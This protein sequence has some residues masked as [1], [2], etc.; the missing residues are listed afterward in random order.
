MSEDQKPE[1]VFVDSLI[2]LCSTSYP[3][4]KQIINKAF[5]VASEGISKV[6]FSLLFQ[7]VVRE[8]SNYLNE[9]PDGGDNEAEDGEVDAENGVDEASQDASEED[10]SEEDEGSHDKNGHIEQDAKLG[11]RG[12]TNGAPN[13]AK[14]VLKSKPEKHRQ[15]GKTGASSN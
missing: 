8:D 4:T 7:A 2:A 10:D 9:D 1:D 12:T 11:K 15:P 3:Q 14:D 13:Q 5:E 6:G